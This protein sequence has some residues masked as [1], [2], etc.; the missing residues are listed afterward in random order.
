MRTKKITLIAT[1][2]APEKAVGSIRTTK[3]VKYLVR[4]NYEVTVISP[5]LNDSSSIDKSLNCHELSKV[6]HINVSHSNLF[7][8]IFLKRRNDFLAKS[9]TGNK[10]NVKPT[11]STLRKIKGNIKIFAHFLYT[12]IRNLDWYIAVR[13][14]KQVNDLIKSSTM[15]LI[16]SYP[17]LSAHWVA[18]YWSKKFN[19]NWIAD[20]RDPINYE[21][22]SNFL[23]YNI[24]TL[25]QKRIVKNATYVTYISKGV[26]KKLDYKQTDSHKFKFIPNGFDYDDIK[27]TKPPV[28]NENLIMSYVGGLYGGER[29][30]SILFKA[31][32][33][34]VD[35]HRINIKDIVLMYAGKEFNV[36]Q[37]QALKYNLE[38]IL[39]NKG[40]VSLEESIE[41]QQNSDIALICTWNTEKDQGIMTG[42]VFESFLASKVILAIING[43]LPESEL[44]HTIAYVNGGFTYEEGA[45]NIQKEYVDLCN[46]ISD[47]VI[48][49]KEFGFVKNEYNDKKDD[50]SYQE[51]SNSFIKLIEAK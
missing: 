9:S 13:R 16:S 50:Y 14:N 45:D 3:L 19:Y 48:E 4:A 39:I 32:R 42:K 28:G 46:F 11:E 20:F 27:E 37:F 35:N 10:L 7:K 34:L 47:R 31:I 23:T 24:Y 41:I 22:N 36:L 43:D 1:A 5:E 29:D 2:F 51:I 26:Y 25:I 15:T 38:K 40:Y 33:E 21:S 12:I 30:M 18:Q 8:K 6:E 49:K 44:K 17:S